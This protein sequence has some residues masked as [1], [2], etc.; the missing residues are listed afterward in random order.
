[1]D[2]LLDTGRV[3]CPTHC[4]IVGDRPRKLLL[5]SQVLQVA[6]S[7]V[8]DRFLF[9]FNHIFLIPIPVMHD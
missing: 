1:M 9:L 4:T 3:V 2:E 7:T 6:N 8:K 5:L